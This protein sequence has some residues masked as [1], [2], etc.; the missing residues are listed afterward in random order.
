MKGGMID[1]S[2]KPDVVRVAIAEGSIRLRPETI[3]LIQE[4]K[5][6][7][8][9]VAEAAKIAAILAVKNTPSILP[10]CHPVPI[11]S[12]KVDVDYDR[13]LVKVIVEV[14]TTYKT[15]VEMEALTGVTAALLT[16]WDM[17]KKY[18]K[19]EEGQYPHTRIVDVRV[20]KKIKKSLKE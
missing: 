7:K 5:I 8:G 2:N 6:E 19:D 15:G 18:E 20:V 9:D 10:Y 14:K 17:V 16:I 12:V 1:I 3:K 13:D 11:T 4:G